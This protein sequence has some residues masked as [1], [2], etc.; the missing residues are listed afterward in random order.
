M[1]KLKNTSVSFFNGIYYPLVIAF[2]VLIGHTFSLELFSIVVAGLSASYGLLICKDLKFVL[3]PALTVFFCLSK[4]SAYNMS[5]KFFTTGSIITVS[6]VASIFVI[7]IIAHFIIFKKETDF[8]SPIKSPLFF[9]FAAF[10]GGIALNGLFGKDSM[11]LKNTAFSI[12]LICSYIVVFYIWYIGIE[13][14][15]NFKKYLMYILLIASILLTLEFYS[16]FLIGQIQFENGEIVKESIVTGWGIWNTMGC[17]LSMLLPVHFYFASHTKKYGFIFYLTGLIS[18]FAIVLSLSRS[19][20]LAGTFVI[21]ISIIASCFSKKNKKINRIITLILGVL[22]VVGIVVFWN[23][24]ANIFGDYLRRGLDDNGRFDIYRFGLKRFL[25]NP[26]FGGGFYNAYYT[27]ETG[28]PFGYH[29]TIVQMLA[30]CGAV[31]LVGYL[32]HR[33]QTVVLAIKKRSF[34]NLFL[35]LC[36]C[37]LL[38]TSLFDVHI[39]SLYPSIYYSIILIAIEKS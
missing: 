34:S 30:S 11:S 35:Y 36:L 33:Y 8:K 32:F 7:A 3:A 20:L 9:G 12:A 24:I 6:F 38:I 4:K 2:S 27:M 18:Y 37:A 15:D 39:I 31:G 21:G 14:N 13:F 10:C 22:G 29:N 23:K 19:S 28:L 5:G 26:V 25:E 17:Y 16:L 1:K